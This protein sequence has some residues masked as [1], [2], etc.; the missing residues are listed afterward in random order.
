MK[1]N[2]LEIIKSDPYLGVATFGSLGWK[3]DNF[4]HEYIYKRLKEF[5]F[6]SEDHERWEATIICSA[7]MAALCHESSENDPYDMDPDLMIDTNEILV[8]GMI[9][10]ENL[11]TI[12]NIEQGWKLVTTQERLNDILDGYIYSIKSVKGISRRHINDLEIDKDHTHVVI[13]QDVT[14]DKPLIGDFDIE[15]FSI[16]VLSGG[17][18]DDDDDDEDDE[19]DDYD[20]DYDDDEDDVDLIHGSYDLDRD[21]SD[22]DY[23]KAGWIDYHYDQIDDIIDTALN[24]PKNRSNLLDGFWNLLEKQSNTD[25]KNLYP[26][27]NL[28]YLSSKEIG[29]I[30]PKSK[31][32]ANKANSEE[33][34]KDIKDI[35]SDIGNPFYEFINSMDSLDD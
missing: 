22:D 3:M 35:I 27:D 4:A 9:H 23:E 1:N 10:P 32:K 21:S 6:S 14:M 15:S 2:I 5:G 17:P 33:S 19:D 24:I 18:Y 12:I 34:K 29:N 11:A 25:N 8:H 28:S 16:G 26:E 30:P 13:L 31:I 20:N 7:L